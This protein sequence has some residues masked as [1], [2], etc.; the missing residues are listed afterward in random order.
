MLDETFHWFPNETGGLLAGYADKKGNVVICRVTKSGPRA[1][2]KTHSYIPDYDYDVER[3][4]RIYKGSKKLQV[5]QGDWHVHPKS[6]A[7]LSKRD[8]ETLSNI[9]KFEEARISTPVMIV[10]GTSPFELKCW[11]LVDSV[12]RELSVTLY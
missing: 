7:Y 5:Y 8:Q 4:K 6:G 12:P 3:I 9:A 10:L 2:H 1:I 11:Q